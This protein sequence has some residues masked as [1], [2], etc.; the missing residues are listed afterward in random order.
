MRNLRMICFLPI[1]AIAASASG[2]DL[3]LVPERVFKD[4]SVT[5]AARETYARPNPPGKTR[6]GSNP[7]IFYLGDST[8]RNGS[9]GNGGNGLGE[10]G[11]AFFA[12]MWFDPEKVT[13]ENHALGGLSARSF[14]RDYWALIK[15][16]LR[17]GANCCNAK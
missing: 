5:A 17:K 6:K 3:R 2:L 15:A 14:Y 4:I 10:W 11:W 7:V 1:V 8:T 12:Q 9:A 16:N 13:C